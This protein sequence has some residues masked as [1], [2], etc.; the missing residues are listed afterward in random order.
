MSYLSRCDQIRPNV[1]RIKW[2]SITGTIEV[3]DGVVWYPRHTRL[4]ELLF[5]NNESER[6]FIAG[7]IERDTGLRPTAWQAAS[8]N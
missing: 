7:T 1:W 3:L 2:R 5:W 4:G 6:H 8:S